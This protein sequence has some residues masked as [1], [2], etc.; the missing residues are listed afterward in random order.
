M[1]LRQLRLSFLVFV[2]IGVVVGAYVKNDRILNFNHGVVN[3]CPEIDKYPKTQQLILWSVADKMHVPEG[4]PLATVPRRNFIDDY[5][6]DKIEQ[7]GIRPANLSGDEEFIRRIYLELT[8]RIPSPQDVRAFLQDPDPGTKRDRVVDR[9]LAGGEFTDKLTLWLGDLLENSARN[10]D[11]GGGGL[12]Y[13]GRTLYYNVIKDAVAQN[14][15]YNE[16]VRNLITAV[17]HSYQVGPANFIAREWYGGYNTQDMQDELVDRVGSAFLGTQLRCVNCH[18]GSRF[19]PANLNLWLQ[20]RRRPELWGMSSFF[21]GVRFN[22]QRYVEGRN[23]YYYNIQEAATQG[24]DTNVN[25]GIRPPRRGVVQDRYVMPRYIFNGEENPD[26]LTSNPRERLAELVTGDPLFA[27]ATVNYLWANLMH[28][29]LIDPPSGIDP[30]RL[31]PTNPPPKPWEIQPSHPQLLNALANELV[32]SGYD[33]RHIIGLITK[34]NAYGLSARYDGVWDEN[35]TRYFAR[36]IVNRLSA[37]QL[38]D[39]IVVA[40]GVA[41]NYKIPQTNE[42]RRNGNCPDV[43]VTVQWAH[44]LPDPTEPSCNQDGGVRG[45]LNTFERGNRYSTERKTPPVGSIS[46]V[47]TLMNNSPVIINRIRNQNALVRRLIND[48]LSDEELVDELFMATLSRLPNERER[49]T[50]RSALAEGNR[51]QAAE[52]LHLALINMIDFLFY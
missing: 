20:Q 1:R 7:A 27:K 5:I 11:N 45:F 12:N 29:G 15:P 21:S 3:H 41:N 6:F 19:A 16:V 22:R 26:W 24:Y 4:T 43:T 49:T 28:L 50:A 47:L 30:D 25:G 37:E 18:D 36:R 2:S 52:D 32:Q 51:Q 34:S 48:G 14:R 9:L 39:A 10:L 38:H 35:Y 8:G 33:L 17:G 31:D 13:T 40:T 23:E 44:Q 42:Q 46:Q